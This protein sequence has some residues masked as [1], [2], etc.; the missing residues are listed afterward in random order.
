MIEAN[1]TKDLFY[2]WKYLTDFR[3]FCELKLYG[4]AQDGAYFAPADL[5]DVH[6]VFSPGYGGV[7]KFEDEMS[8]L[9][10]KVFICDPSYESIPDLKDSQSFQRVC[11]STSTSVSQNKISL[12][13]WLEKNKCGNRNNMLLQMDIEG[14]EWEILNQLD[15]GTLEKFKCL[16]IEFHNLEK[17]I[18]EREFLSLSINVLEKVD[19]H[20]INVF[21]RANNAGGFVYLLGQKFP[22]V[23]E[24]TL[25]NRQSKFVSHV[26]KHSRAPS[27][28]DFLNDPEKAILRLPKLNF[29]AHLGNF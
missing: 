23:V 7:K 25:V 11:L 10:K 1:S 2:A 28:K 8:Q 21:S 16:I 19:K 17:L 24:V 27:S 18:Y 22:K 12:D 5:Q 4:G 26:A 14:A 20:F 29:G 3:D 15:N 9:G 6:Y 13:D